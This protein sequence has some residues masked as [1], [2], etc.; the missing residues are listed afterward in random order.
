MVQVI[1][2]TMIFIIK[3]T[4]SFILIS[5]KYKVSGFILKIKKIMYVTRISLFKRF[6]TFNEIFVVYVYVFLKYNVY[7]IV[8]LG[9]LKS[10]A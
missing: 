7:R 2:F 5:G 10:I 6:N 1:K 9:L 8:N 3:I 4:K